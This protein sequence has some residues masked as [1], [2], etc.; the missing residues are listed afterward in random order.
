MIQRV[1]D[2]K[3]IDEAAAEKDLVGNGSLIRFVSNQSNRLFA[4]KVAQPK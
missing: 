2:S 4:F 1:V 3:H